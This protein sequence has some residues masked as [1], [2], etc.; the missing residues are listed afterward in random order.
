MAPTPL[1]PAHPFF[2]AMQFACMVGAVS[3]F[4]WFADGMSLSHIAM[5]CVGMGTALW[6]LGRFLQSQL[7]ML[8]VLMV[9]AAVCACLSAVGI[10]PWFMLFKPLVMSLG[11]VFIAQTAFYSPAGTPGVPRKNMVLLLGAIVFSLGGDVFLMLPSDYFIPGLASFLVAHIFYIVLFKQDSRWFASR[12]ALLGVLAVGGLMYAILW[13]QLPDAALK[14]AVACYVT[15]I[16]VMVAQAIGRATQLQ[17]SGATWVALAAAVFMLSD[18]LI[19]I[20]KFLLPIPLADL[21]ILATYY[22]AQ[23]IIMHFTLKVHN[24]PIASVQG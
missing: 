18:T 12:F 4:L 3:L 14:I 19:A 5:V 10:L 9:Q 13:R 16:G 24:N 22:T 7:R 17:H 20:N 8:E 1:S 15:V 23:I 6:A 2:A 11:I 21:W